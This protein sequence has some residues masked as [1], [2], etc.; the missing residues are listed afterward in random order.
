[1]QPHKQQLFEIFNGLKKY[2]EALATKSLRT[3]ELEETSYSLSYPF[4]FL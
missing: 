3:T 1:M 4:L 2:K